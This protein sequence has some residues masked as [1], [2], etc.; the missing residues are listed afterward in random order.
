MASA[1]LNLLIALG[2]NLA[3]V[4][5]ATSASGPIRPGYWES[6]SRVTSPIE[7]TKT[8]RRCITPRAV[9]KFMGCYLNHHYTCACPKQ[10]YSD[11]QISFHGDCV[12]AKRRHVRIDG[13]GTYTPTTLQMTAR[14][15]F[16]LMGLSIPFSASTESHW[17]SEDC[18]AAAAGAPVEE[19]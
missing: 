8:D 12:D 1:S 5:Q 6:T 16:T 19:K 17:I 13:E 14:G 10:S 15:H 18:P 7:S 4:G 9:A 3:L 2:A 11:G